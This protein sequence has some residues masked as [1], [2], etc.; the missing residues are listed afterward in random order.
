MNV[1]IKALS[2]LGLA[3]LTGC[4]CVESVYE[5]Q[6]EN[7]KLQIKNRSLSADATNIGPAPTDIGEFKARFF[8]VC[9]SFCNQLE[10]RPIDFHTGDFKEKSTAG[11]CY[12]FNKEPLPIKP[13]NVIVLGREFWQ[14][15]F[16]PYVVKNEEAIKAKKLHLFYH[17]M[18]HCVTG[19]G[20]RP[21]GLMEPAMNLVT[22]PQEADNQLL[23]EIE[24]FKIRGLDGYSYKNADG[25]GFNK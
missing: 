13:N 18:F 6:K 1:T 17:E 25:T 22:V 16:F 21:K 15:P 4:G 19:A 7:V 12:M 3:I 20:H 24:Y 14:N 10:F 8:D 2:L 5:E 23:D 9:G 11:I